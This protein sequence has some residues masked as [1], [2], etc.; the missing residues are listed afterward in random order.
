M[1]Q[2]AEV[3]RLVWID[4]AKGNPVPI[5]FFDGI[6][7]VP[8]DSSA[9]L[10][11]KELLL[12]TLDLPTM[13]RNS[14]LEK[15][16]QGN[17]ELKNRIQLL[18]KNV[19][20]SGSFMAE[21]VVDLNRT[22]AMDPVE[23]G[24]HIDRY[25]IMEQL[26]EGGMGIVFVAEQT[27]PV[28]R[29]VALKIIK[30]GMDSKAVVARFEAERQALAMMDH[31]NIARVLDAGTTREKLPYFV[32]EL[33]RGLPITQYCDQ[34]K[35]SLHERLKLFVS[36]CNAVQ[37]AHQKGIIHRDIKPGNVLVTLHDGKP[38]VKVIDFGVA[39][40]IHQSLS[41]H[42]VYTA[43]NQV[44][45]TP[46]YMS[47]EQM[48]LSGLDIDT[49]TD[50]YSL[51]VLL[52]EIITGS[53]PFDRERLLRSG[54]DEM[55]RIIREEDPQR[56]SQRITTLPKAELSTFANNRG[57]D[58]RALTQ[59][60]QSELDWITMKALEKDRN[61]R[62]ESSSSLGADV[63]RFLND[64]PV[65]ACPPS[66]AYRAKKL[67][68][69]YRVLLTTGTLVVIALLIGTSVSIWQAIRA[70]EAKQIAVA[71]NGV[72]KQVV[73]D[74]YTQFAERWLAEQGNASQL[75]REFLEKAAAF[76]EANANQQSNDLNFVIDRLKSRERVCNIQVKLGQHQEA[77]KGL[78]DLIVSCRQYQASDPARIEF[79]MAELRSSVSLSSLLYTTGQD[80]AAKSEYEKT[81]V[82][83]RKVAAST[84]LDASQKSE[85]A[86]ISAQLCAEL[87][88]RKLT[89]A[90]E[91]AIQTS[92]ELWTE[93]LVADPNDWS[94]RIGLAEALRRQGQ[95]RMWFGD[96]KV[97]AETVFLQANEMF[98]QLLKERPRDR[99]CRQS[100]AS[101]YLSLG[102]LAGWARQNERKLEYEKQGIEIARI[103]V[104]DF[105]SDQ[106]ALTQLISLQGNLYSSLKTL[107]AIDEAK[108]LF[109]TYY[110]SSEKLVDLFPT[111]VDF[112]SKY[113][114]A[115]RIASL[116]LY[117]SGD[118]TAALSIASRCKERIA[119]IRNKS[120]ENNVAYVADFE[121]LAT[122]NY[123]SLL[124]E[125]GRYLDAMKSLETLDI[126]RYAFNLARLNKSTVI[127][128]DE[129]F[130]LACTQE[131]P[132]LKV[133]SWMIGEC[134]DAVEKDPLLT[135]SSKRE[136]TATLRQFAEHCEAEAQKLY[137]VWHEKLDSVSLSS[138]KLFSLF[139]NFIPQGDPGLR[140]EERLNAE[141]SGRLAMDLIRKI[142][143]LGKDAAPNHLSFIIG[144]LT[145]GKEYLRDAE[146]AMRLAKRALEMQPNSG[147]AK[148]DLAWALFRSGSYGESLKLQGTKIPKKDATTNA[149]LAMT[150]WHLGRKQ[151]AA[152]C[153]DKPYDENLTAYIAAREKDAKGANVHPTAANIIRLDREA[154]ALLGDERTALA[155]A[156]ADADVKSPT[157]APK[158][159]AKADPIK[160]LR[161]IAKWQFENHLEKEAEDSLSDLIRLQPNSEDR[162]AWKARGDLR[163]RFKRYEEALNDLNYVLETTPD[164]AV[165]LLHRCY[166]YRDLNRFDEA[167]NDAN[168]LIELA[169]TGYRRWLNR[170]EV[171]EKMKQPKQSIADI[172]KALEVSAGTFDPWYEVSE[173]FALRGRVYLDGLAD[174]EQAIA[175]F[176]HALE[177]NLFSGKQF[178]K[179]DVLLLRAAAYDLQGD[180]E[181]AKQDRTAAAD[182]KH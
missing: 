109:R 28:R 57:L 92:L 158:V 3:L 117:K 174:S 59:L 56:P 157:S 55:R 46:L 8:D 104:Q 173:V 66:V 119:L 135:I 11:E 115:S 100:L 6:L 152:A 153:L 172:Q 38:V 162:A 89:E 102:V 32:M 176:T 147:M 83:R 49:R 127:L 132:G 29:R 51:G 17:R 7:I 110:E 58:D 96:R 144:E 72:A 22:T 182:L 36:V 37:H 95:Q 62:Y 4:R 15:A 142:D 20:E 156:F 169:P 88:K 175:D 166:C 177:R 9:E 141:T 14:Y 34:A 97:E 154:K 148:Q 74:M 52:Y 159:Q 78:R 77:E 118:R 120:S 81:D 125:E 181:K 94:Y 75:Q 146:L 47:P 67:M 122:L 69:R 13:E 133:P 80:D 138:G 180:A 31:P 111:V 63:Q 42:T 43:L 171:Y 71:S 5:T 103:L 145:A 70:N 18:L 90:A 16:C 165:V 114:R 10:N 40:A 106:E 41:Q 65:L 129:R 99:A 35:T 178:S 121:N 170:A 64:E 130:L 48:E 93:L 112:A 68:R 149:V 116:E 168:K 2:S 79:A 108:D 101:T 85:L 160:A 44:V 53:T 151:E 164:D 91:A 27:E 98:R 45:G 84:T 161:A 143:E 179:H 50:I 82:C 139:R 163:W 1:R 60:V 73:D 124:L 26:G 12:A 140:S 105:P 33:V 137:N 23:V 86:S 155:A 126:D 30:P 131:Y 123:V 128:A 39:K 113:V 54:F 61:R 76:Y 150:F 24:R 107:G 19:E 21:P 167:L 134:F 25:R 87:Q 136:L